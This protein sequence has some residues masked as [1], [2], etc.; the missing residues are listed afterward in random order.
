[1]IPGSD[2][3]VDAGCFISGLGNFKPFSLLVD[4]AAFTFFLYSRIFKTDLLN[5]LK[6]PHFLSL[7]VYVHYLGF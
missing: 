7:C 6:R 5:S 4:T 1:M 2:A 3:S